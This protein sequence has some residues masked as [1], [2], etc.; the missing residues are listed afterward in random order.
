M[1]QQ[2]IDNLTQAD[3]EFRA[4]E[5]WKKVETAEGAANSARSEWIPFRDE[6]EARKMVRAKFT[7]MRARGEI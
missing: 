6:L 4:A 7:A 5:A 1:N 2:E 3:L